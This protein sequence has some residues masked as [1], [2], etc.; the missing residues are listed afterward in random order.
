MFF[1][2]IYIFVPSRLIVITWL[3]LQIIK[4]DLSLVALYC[5]L[6]TNKNKI[7]WLSC[8]CIQLLFVKKKLST[9]SL[10]YYLQNISSFF[11]FLLYRKTHWS[12]LPVIPFNPVKLSQNEGLKVRIIIFQKSNEH[13]VLRTDSWKSKKPKIQTCYYLYASDLI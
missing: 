12:T 3:G 13:S 2:H 5:P 7:W 11:F 10:F 1:I 9:N 4:Q 8:L 6:S